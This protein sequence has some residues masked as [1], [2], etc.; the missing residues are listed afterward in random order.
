VDEHFFKDCEVA[1]A[2]VAGWT[3]VMQNL[4]RTIPDQAR[5]LENLKTLIGRRLALLNSRIQLRREKGVQAAAD[6]VA[7]G[8]ARS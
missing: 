6:A 8:R 2:R 7:T 3:D 4:S 5:R 1:Q